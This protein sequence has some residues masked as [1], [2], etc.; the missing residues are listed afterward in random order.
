MNN[1]LQAALKLFGQKL[2]EV[3]TENAMTQ[4]DL[5]EFIAKD[6]NTI[7]LLETGRRMP[8]RQEMDIFCDYL[9]KKEEYF[10]PNGIPVL[11]I[12]KAAKPMQSKSNY[13]GKGYDITKD[14]TIAVD[15]EKGKISAIAGVKQTKNYTRKIN[16]AE[17]GIS[18]DVEQDLKSTANDEV[19]ITSV[20]DSSKE[21]PS[22]AVQE[23]TKTI[24]SSNIEFKIP[25]FD[26]FITAKITQEITELEIPCGSQMMTIKITK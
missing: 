2:K 13:E 22:I 9:N 19:A 24:S 25:C 16:E 20:V 12:D 21:E 4:K 26:S 23:E 8:F 15:Y 7:Y 10:F 3:R 6:G 5:A 18:Y 11:K 17:I 1:E 14:N